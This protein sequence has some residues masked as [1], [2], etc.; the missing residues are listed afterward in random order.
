MA[1]HSGTAG[2]WRSGGTAAALILLP[3]LAMQFTQ[4]VNWGLEDFAFATLMVVGVGVTYELAVRMSG[5]RAY[6]AGAAVA[7]AAA[8]VL[9]W[10]NAAVGIIG[11]E[12]NSINWLFDAV[13]VVGIVGAL[14]ARFQ[15]MGMARAMTATALAQVLV[16]VIALAA[17]FGFT[18][19]ATVF[20]TGMWLISAWL[21]R[22]VAPA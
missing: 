2:G 16:A 20:F 11:S 9:V 14:V 4:E 13:P 10:S 12:D 7:L 5:N 1:D 19:P 15:A 8:F 21:F 18:G 22:R 3:L 6:R 17:G